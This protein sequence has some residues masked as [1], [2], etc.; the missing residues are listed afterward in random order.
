MIKR[1]LATSLLL[2]SVLPALVQAGAYDDLIKAADQNDGAEVTTLLRRGADPNT[3][4]GDGTTLLMSA[5]RNGNEELVDVLLQM[6]AK[7]RG[8]NRYGDD[9]LLLA[10]FR[11]YLGIVRKLVA[12]GAPVNRDEG[13]Q[14]LAYAAFNGH[15]EVAQFLLEHEADVDAMSDNGTSALMVAARNGHLEVVKLLLKHEADPDIE[16][17][18][19]GT[20][21]SWAEAAGN[22]EIARLVRKA[23]DASA[24]ERREAARLYAIRQA[25]EARQAAERARLEKEAQEKAAAEAASQENAPPTFG[26]IQ[27]K[28]E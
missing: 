5:A 21:L 9:A 10:A 6:R 27:T 18:V 12:A 13:W 15:L 17:D 16:N 14:P 7:V 19:G 26:P 11:G 28:P 22:T 3:A 20:A 2:L 4:D 1:L 8:R 23:M 25:E 24:A